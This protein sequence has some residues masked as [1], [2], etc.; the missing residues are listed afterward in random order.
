MPRD[1]HYDPTWEQEHDWIAKCPKD[2]I[3]ALCKACWS[4]FSIKNSSVTD[5]RKHVGSAKHEKAYNI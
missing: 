1:S 3:K 4:E 5:I 2:V